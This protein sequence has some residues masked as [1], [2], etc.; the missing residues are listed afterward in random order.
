MDVVYG[1]NKYI[2]VGDFGTIVSSIDGIT[3][4][5]INSG[6]SEMLWAVSY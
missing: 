1:N 5:N 3:W 2:A 4:T 6:F